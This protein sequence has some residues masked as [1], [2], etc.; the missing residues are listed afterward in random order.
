MHQ[1]INTL[2][3]NLAT[4]G[5][6]GKIPKAPGTWGSIPGLFLG[7]WLYLGTN[8]DPYTI[9][10]WLVLFT[11]A[12]WWTIELV[13]RAFRIHDDQRIV[14]DEVCGQAIV[15]AFFE[16]NLVTYLIAFG[17]FRLFDI[18]KPGIIGYIDEKLPGGM[19]TLFDDVAA[20]L[21]SLG[22]LLLLIKFFSFA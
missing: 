22:C 13:E 8:G 4:V 20:G 21:I 7:A 10:L 5:P 17:L 11:L 16:P 2:L 12:S 9:S 18:T 19:G 15:C 1:F 6:I 14:L 3:W